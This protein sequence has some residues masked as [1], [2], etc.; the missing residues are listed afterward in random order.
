[1]FTFCSI[2]FKKGE[3]HIYIFCVWIE[4]CTEYAFCSIL[5][6]KDKQCID[7]SFIS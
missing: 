4:T 2:L 7:L 3:K 1:M 5:F 6:K